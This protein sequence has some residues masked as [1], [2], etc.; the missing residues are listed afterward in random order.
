MTTLVSAPY[1]D[2]YAKARCVVSASA[3]VQPAST[4]T[5]NQSLMGRMA[6]GRPWV[7][8]W[9]LSQTWCVCRSSHA[10]AARFR[11]QR[12]APACHTTTTR[13]PRA[14]AA[15]MTWTLQRNPCLSAGACTA[16]HKHSRAAGRA[17]QQAGQQ[18]GQGS[19]Q[20]RAA[21]RAGQ[22]RAGQGRA[23]QGRAGQG[24]AGQGRAGQGRAA[25][26]AAGRVC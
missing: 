21:G 26:T 24:R 14:T 13:P 3:L 20:G 12:T 18:A 4:H 25:D 1:Y 7:N 22:G 5:F 17:K 16:T 9:H 2:I 11:P 19:R 23:G 15:R 8:L 10:T 6:R